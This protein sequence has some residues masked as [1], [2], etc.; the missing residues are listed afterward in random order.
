[1]ATVTAPQPGVAR[2]GLSAPVVFIGLVVSA[3]FAQV[4]ISFEPIDA[5]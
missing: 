3:V 4:L 5:Q 2:H 1:V